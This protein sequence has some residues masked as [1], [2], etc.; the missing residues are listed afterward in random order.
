MSYLIPKWLICL[1]LNH[2]WIL[3][4]F[5]NLHH[6]VEFSYQC[7]I[8]I[9]MLSFHHKNNFYHDGNFH[10]KDSLKWFIFIIMINFIKT[11]NFYQPQLILKF[12]LKYYHHELLFLQ[13][14]IIDENLV[15]SFGSSFN[16]WLRVG[17]KKSF[18][19]I[20]LYA[21]IFILLQLWALE[22]HYCTI[23][24]VRVS[25]NIGLDVFSLLQTIFLYVSML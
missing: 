19:K 9:T 10:Q 16:L 4:L 2:W 12:S 6:N 1:P 18:C 7:L 11:R 25:S 14:F 21:D 5:M 20:L 24:E 17:I 13:C 22:G 3:I 8:F 23:F 15:V